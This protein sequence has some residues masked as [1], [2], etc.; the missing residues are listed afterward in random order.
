MSRIVQPR[1]RL[2]LHLCPN[3]YSSYRLIDPAP[4][5][6][7]LCEMLK[8][9]T[10]I[11]GSTIFLA[12]GFALLPGCVGTHTTDKPGQS[13]W[14]NLKPLIAMETAPTYHLLDGYDPKWMVQIKEGIEIARSYWGSFG[15]T[16]VW[17][18]GREPGTVIT[19]K[20]R[21]DFLEQYC[22]WRT[23]SSART[24][25][26]CLPYAKKRLFT[27]M[28]RGDSECW[29]SDTRDTKPRMAELF[30]INVHKQ[31][32]KGEPIPGPVVRGVHEYTHVFQQSTGP[33]PTWMAEGGA[34]F[35][36]NWL[37]WQQGRGNPKFI[38]KHL[39]RNVHRKLGDTGFSIADMESI[40]SAPTEV[41]RYYL[42][43]AYYSGAWATV[44]MI[45][46]SP[47]NRV[48]TLRDVFYPLV[49]QFGWETA[50]C[51]YVGMQNKAEFYEAFAVFMDLPIAKQLAVWDTLKS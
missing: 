4:R 18:L 41:A 36:E 49:K 25:S 3:I 39:M 42:E 31:L 19:K 21:R 2:S 6:A 43:L 12:M 44:F 47:T 10:Q 34:V 11:I 9:S 5:R 24:F 23:A 37:P 7:T 32:R 8:P 48:A 14:E 35:A 29:L 46:K 30:F 13:P 45:H 16:H 20:S 38:M 28:D 51:R 15:P 40:E 27:R 1:H 17:I 22:T 26:E 50:L 33:I